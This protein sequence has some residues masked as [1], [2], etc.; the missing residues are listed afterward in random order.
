MNKAQMLSLYVTITIITTRIAPE[1]AGAASCAC[2]C[3]DRPFNGV[4]RLVLNDVFMDR[5]K[6]AVK[7][8]R[9]TGNAG[10]FLRICS[11]NTCISYDERLSVFCCCPLYPTL[12]CVGVVRKR[13]LCVESYIWEW[14]QVILVTVTVH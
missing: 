9:T 14:V 8:G 11:T 6:E 5:T 2:I 12:Y 7:Q 4:L 13:H 1:V 3:P 10:R